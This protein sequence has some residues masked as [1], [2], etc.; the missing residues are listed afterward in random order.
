MWRYVNEEEVVNIVKKFYVM[1][2]IVT[3]CEEVYKYTKNKW[4]VNKGNMT[5]DFTV[6]ILFFE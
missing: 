3:A 6:I 2:D 1:N 4:V 5:E